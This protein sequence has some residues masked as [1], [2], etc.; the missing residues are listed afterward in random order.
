MKEFLLNMLSGSSSVS[1]KRVAMWF[2]S[3]VFVF[4]V[5]LNAFRPDR[6]PSELFQNQLFEILMTLILLVFGER[7]LSAWQAIRN[8]RKDDQQTP[9]LP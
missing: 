7:A 4:L 2:F 8:K 6:H 3:F 9:P 1:S 5:I